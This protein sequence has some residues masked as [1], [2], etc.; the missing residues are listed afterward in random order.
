MVKKKKATQAVEHKKRKRKTK[1]TQLSSFV[2][3][4]KKKAARPDR[5][6]LKAIYK[7]MMTALPEARINALITAVKWYDAALDWVRD[8]DRKNVKLQSLIKQRTLEAIDDI[9]EMS[10]NTPHI[11]RREEL[12]KKLITKF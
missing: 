10:L 7:L 9:R 1:H 8:D 6:Q 12:L 11:Q 5:R 3:S 2:G 4:K